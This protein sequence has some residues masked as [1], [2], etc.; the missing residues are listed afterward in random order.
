MGYRTVYKC[1][2]CGVEHDDGEATKDWEEVSLECSY[3]RLSVGDGCLVFTK[4]RLFKK[5]LVCSVA[6]FV[7]ALRMAADLL[8][9]R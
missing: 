7:R 6:C 4:E 1:D 9:A 3:G 8:A 5:P 2:V